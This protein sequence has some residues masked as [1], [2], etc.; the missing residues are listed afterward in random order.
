MTWW[1]KRTTEREA[2]RQTLTNIQVKTQLEIAL[3]DMRRAFE[4]MEVAVAQIPE[5]D[6]P[7][8]V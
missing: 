5:E 6:G 1:R 7:V 2:L 4:S 3:R 8:G